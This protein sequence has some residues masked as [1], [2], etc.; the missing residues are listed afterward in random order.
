MFIEQVYIR[1]IIVL[2]IK[3]VFMNDKTYAQILQFNITNMGF[4]VL[5]WKIWCD[6]KLGKE[7]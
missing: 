5:S 1:P 3:S 6:E 2:A 7:I 4:K